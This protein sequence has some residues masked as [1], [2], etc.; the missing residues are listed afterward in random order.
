MR[1]LGKLPTESEA[2]RLA[3]YLVTQRIDAHAESEGDEW[4]VWVRDED[5]L[6]EAREAMAHFREHPQDERY[7]GAEG[8]AQRK[9]REE[10]R[11]RERARGNV[12][13]MRGRWGRGI[14]G[15]SRR[16]PLVLALIGIS[17]LVSLAA[18]TL[19]DR[20][21]ARESVLAKL[22]FVEPTLENLPGP[23]FDVFANVRRGEIWRLISPVFIHYSIWHLVFNMFWLWDIGGQIE[24]R[25]GTW[26][27]LV[28]VLILAVLPVL[29][30]AI[31][32]AI[33]GGR[34]FAFGGM[35]GVGYG[36]FGYMLVKVRMGNAEHYVL[37]PTTIFIGILWFVL[38][39]ARSF[40]GPDGW[41]SFLPEI[42]NSAHTVGLF[43]GMAIA[44]FPI[45]LR[46]G[47]KT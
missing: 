7:R 30:Q 24:T 26:R 36:L 23:S 31:E 45:T 25:R 18:N 43:A 1:Q 46:G 12:V 17:I 3:A 32:C 13:E 14:G 42:A 41:L 4:A 33:S 28:L 39:L 27:M 22:I 9:R 2:Q 35:S 5:H 40:T 10:D 19:S 6:A 38:C 20:R 34:G 8:A 29:G 44:Y 11:Q 37:N 15:A 16:C 47:E 21:P